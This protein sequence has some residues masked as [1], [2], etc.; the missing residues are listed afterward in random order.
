MKKIILQT[1]SGGYDST[2]L[3][4][5]NLK[6]GHDVHPVFIFSRSVNPLKQSIE[7][8]AVKKLM[9]KLQCFDNLHGLTETEI[10][11]NNIQGL[12]STQPILWLFGLFNE[13]MNI[14]HFI[15]FDEVHL[16]YVM[17]DGAVSFLPEIMKYWKILF[18]FSLPEYKAPKLAFPLMKYHKTTILDKLDDFDREILDDCWFCEN[19]KVIKIKNVKNGD[20]EI[21]LEACCEC[22]PCTRIKNTHNNKFNA[23]KKYKAKFCYT[24]FYNG[25]EKAVKIIEKDKRLYNIPCNYLT[26]EEIDEKTIKKLERFKETEKPSKILKHIKKTTQTL[27]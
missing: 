22:H 18:S 10:N 16:G 2:Y 9:K 1:I 5:K 14:R 24:D 25:L 6:E 23:L 26:V 8:H 19:P 20:K 3:L 4:I 21:Y 27:S 12:F 7:Y 17:T 15:D 13:V 11:L